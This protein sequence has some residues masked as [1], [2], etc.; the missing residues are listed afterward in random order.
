MSAIKLGVQ[1]STY[2]P[3]STH[4]ETFATAQQE[5]RELTQKLHQ[6][7][8][9]IQQIKTMMKDLNIPYLDNCCE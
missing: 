5:Y 8:L 6:A 2:G 9:K 3:T 4:L 7:G 1:F